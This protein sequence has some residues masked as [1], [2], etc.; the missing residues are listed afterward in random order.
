MKPYQIVLLVVSLI[1]FFYVAVLLYSTASSLSFKHKLK[2]R[3]NTL[4]VLL[5][6][7][8]EQLKRIDALMQNKGVVYAFSDK[9]AIEKMNALDLER[10]LFA[11][12]RPNFEILSETKSRLFHLCESSSIPNESEILDAKSVIE[13]LERS[14]RLCSSL[15]NSDVIALNYWLSVPLCG[16]VSFLLGCRKADSI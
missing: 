13:D 4:S 16:W 5:V 14:Y 3:L 2:I 10:P 7:E 11:S 8:R 6:E 9:Q 1:A 12:I 15:Y